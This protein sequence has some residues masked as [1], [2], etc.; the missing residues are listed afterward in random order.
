MS[1][2]VISLLFITFAAIIASGW[3]IDRAFSRY[4]QQANSQSQSA[5]AQYG[6]S[7]ANLLNTSPQPH[8]LVT[9]WNA[10][11]EHNVLLLDET[12]L[13]LPSTLEQALTDDGHITL[14]SDAGVTMYFNVPQ[15]HLILA[16]NRSDIHTGIS[17]TQIIFTLAFYCSIFVVLMLWLAPLLL[18]LKRLRTA[19]IGFGLGDLKQRIPLSRWSHTRDIHSAFNSM[20]EKIEQLLND[21]KLLSNALSHELKTPLARLRF[22]FDVLAEEENN[23]RKQQHTHRINEDLNEMQSIINALLDY[24]RLDSVDGRLKKQ[25]FD[26]QARLNDSVHA[27][28]VEAKKIDVQNCHA[29][30]IECDPKHFDLVLS[31]LIKNA[32]LYSNSHIAIRTEASATQFSIFIEDD[33]PGISDLEASTLFKPFVRGKH[34]AGQSGHGMGLAIVNRVAQWN[35]WRVTVGRSPSLGGAQFCLVLPLALQA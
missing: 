3:V 6:Q 2:I 14:Q 26:A 9:S 11:S 7:L 21:N 35:K 8:H 17:A 22:G 13:V 12:D 30:T 25:A 10:S 23:E 20:A 27:Q 33:G 34:T 29:A 28:W 16:V 31:N 5:D 15:H 24:A 18:D 4:S 19:A 32:L 1:R